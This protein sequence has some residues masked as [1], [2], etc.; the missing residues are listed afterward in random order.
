[1]SYVLG[2]LTNTISG[3]RWPIYDFKFL[4]N[5]PPQILMFGGTMKKNFRRSCADPFPPNHEPSA[6]LII[7]YMM[8][9]VTVNINAMS[10]VGRPIFARLTKLCKTNLN[11]YI[12]LPIWPFAPCGLLYPL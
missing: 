11:R 5:A 10:H 2:L 4:N 1:M 8:I 6:P 9:V 3:T 12:V 7:L